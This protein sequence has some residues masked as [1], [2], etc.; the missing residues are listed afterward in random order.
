MF[1][2]IKSLTKSVIG[3][4]GIQTVR[5]LKKFPDSIL[6][7]SKIAI[8]RYDD[9]V[10]K[11]WQERGKKTHLS[12]EQIDGYEKMHSEW[13]PF[14]EEMIQ[15]MRRVFEGHL[16]S[17][18]KFLDYACGTG[19]YI[20]PIRSL[21]DIEVTG[22]DLSPSIL[23]EFTKKKY[24]DVRFECIDLSEKS[25]QVESFVERNKGQFSGACI[26]SAIQYMRYDRVNL[27]LSRIHKVLKPN[28]LFFL[29]FPTP[30]NVWDVFSDIKYIR[31]TPKMIQ[32][33][34]ERV[35]FEMLDSYSV[36][37]RTTFQY[38]RPKKENDQ[39]YVI[40]SKAR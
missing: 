16:K 35:G 40:V 38:F 15:D 9:Q 2:E 36:R 37:Y 5:E 28:A 31:Y 33:K 32:S 11:S 21:G 25:V 27:V 7:L 17:G 4:K 29:Q 39:G 12:E 1:Q 13:K 34:L 8:G 14:I 10:L 3:E 26:N 30:S 19:R 18:D 22:L 24:P 23:E 6:N 20:D